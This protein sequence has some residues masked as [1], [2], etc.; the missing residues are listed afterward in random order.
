ME[1]NTSENN[2]ALLETNS[3]SEAVEAAESTLPAGLVEA[4][5]ELDALS[6]E[7]LEA[8]TMGTEPTQEEVGS[9]LSL[10]ELSSM[11]PEEVEKLVE[12]S[13]QPNLGNSIDQESI[14][15]AYFGDERY[16]EVYA[17]VKSKL[18]DIVSDVTPENN[19]TLFFK[20]LTE[21]ISA[22][23]GFEE[24][25]IADNSNYTLEAIRNLFGLTVRHLSLY[26]SLEAGGQGLKLHS[27]GLYTNLIYDVFT[28]TAGV[29]VLLTNFGENVKELP[30]PEFRLTDMVIVN[31]VVVSSVIGAFTLLLNKL[32][33]LEVANVL[34]VDVESTTEDEI[35]AFIK[36]FNEL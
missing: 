27:D 23:I 18:S 33:A 26:L 35:Q 7:E 11:T 2:K 5:A 13:M 36:I 30:N 34:P 17:L 9:N 10:E 32:I 1:N 4:H 19:R 29:N 3:T 22:S 6:L 25:F 12:Q 28:N 15:K 21:V 31:P 16:T 8:R 24:N 20:N 14:N